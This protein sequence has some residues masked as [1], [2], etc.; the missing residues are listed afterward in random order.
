MVLS[1][2]RTRLEKQPVFAD[3]QDWQVLEDGHEIG[4]IYEQH[5]PASPDQAWFWSITVP[6]DMRAKVV[7]SGRA[8]T[9][10][11]AKQISQRAGP[12]G[13]LGYRADG[14]DSDGLASILLACCLSVSVR[15]KSRFGRVIAHCTTA[16]GGSNT[17]GWGEPVPA[18]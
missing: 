14:L 9:I 3:L 16:R 1:L 13:P 6:L 18:L 7:T 4:R 5:A 8:P 17:G 10:D 11:Q 2:R 15:S 12:P